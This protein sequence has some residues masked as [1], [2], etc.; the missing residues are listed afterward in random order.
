MRTISLRRLK[1]APEH[2]VLFEGKFQTPDKK[3]RIG[4]DEMTETFSVVVLL[5]NNSEYLNECLDS[6]IAQD[7]PSI[8]IIVADDGSKSFE[9]EHIISYLGSKKKE[10]LI[11][12]IVYQNEKNY[13]TVK[14]ANGAI[15]K[16]SGKYIKLLAADDA[17]YD[18]YSLT[19][20]AKALQKSPSGVIT[21]DVMRCDENLKPIAKYRNKLP[22]A[23]NDLE[24][25]DVFRR[26]CVHNDIVAGGVFFSRD[27]FESYGYFDESFR[28]MEDWPTWLKATQHGCRFLYS[29]FFA[30]RYRSNGGIGTSFNPI[31]MADKKRA[32][33]T[34]IIPAKKD[35][36]IR[37]YI[38]ARLSFLMINSPFVRKVYGFIFRKGK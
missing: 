22:E 8:E 2:F 34:I 12:Y 31:Y 16:A 20:A 19:Y 32:L 23:L 26:L 37:W 7:Y 25:L 14:S 13:G 28:L 15:R 18:E 33:D 35:I 6:I 5:Y 38:K 29:P 17:L 30:I 27:F 36:G 1:K 21:G 3:Q 11:N 9:R 4:R 24:P 10:N